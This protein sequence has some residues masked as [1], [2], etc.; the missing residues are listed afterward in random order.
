[1]DAV[2]KHALLISSPRDMRDKNLYTQI[3]YSL[4]NEY[5]L[6]IFEVFDI[7][8]ISGQARGLKLESD[9]N[10]DLRPTKDRVKES[11]FDILHFDIAGKTFLDLFGGTGQI[12]IEA[13]SQGAGKV[14]IVEMQKSNFRIIEKNISKI[15]VPH[16]IELYHA[17]ALKFLKNTRLNIDIAFLDPPYNNTELLEKS[18]E[19]TANI[20][21][22]S[23]II[24]TETLSAQNIQNKTK[25]FSLQKRY[26]YGNISLNLYKKELSKF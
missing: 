7:K 21:N 14:I 2:F 15:K 6:N 16:K 26:N 3:S 19:L 23:G 5:L 12:G 11:L 13:F 24:I 22:K 20:I 4:S 1:M 8:V 18:L 9:K 17:D 25:D 10:K